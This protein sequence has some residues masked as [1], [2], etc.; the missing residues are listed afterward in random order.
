MTA[1]PSTEQAAG[2]TF[3]VLSSAA[4]QR[5]LLASLLVLA[6][7]I[8]TAQPVGP[9]SFV[10]GH[11]SLA[12]EAGSSSQ[13]APRPEWFLISGKAEVQING[14]SLSAKFFDSR[15]PDEVSHEF[16]ASLSPAPGTAKRTQA[17][18]LSAKLRTMNADSG[19][20]VLAGSFFV[21][22]SNTGGGRFVHRSLVVQNPFS[23]V[24]ISCYGKRAA[25]YLPPGRS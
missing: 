18:V 3:R 4:L 20:D 15:S 9:C 7:S 22:P 1:E 12:G 17:K 11:G 21:A 6:P 5:R 14:A 13:A 24:G 10:V 25:L 23:F 2:C 19:I 8:G 16:V